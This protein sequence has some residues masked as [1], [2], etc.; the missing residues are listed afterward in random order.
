MLWQDAFLLQFVK[1][2]DAGS[3]PSGEETAGPQFNLQSSKTLSFY[4]YKDTVI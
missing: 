2:I 4:I 1:P 3:S